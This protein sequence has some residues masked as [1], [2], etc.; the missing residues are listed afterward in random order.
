MVRAQLV[1]P[2]VRGRGGPWLRSS[3][4]RTACLLEAVE[5]PGDDGAADGR[6]HGGEV[7]V[8]ADGLGQLDLAV[9]EVV[10]FGAVLVVFLEPVLPT[11]G[12]RP[13]TAGPWPRSPSSDDRR[14]APRGCGGC[15]TP[16]SAPHAPRRS[17]RRPGQRR[18]R[19]PGGGTGRGGPAGGRRWWAPGAGTPTPTP[20]CGHPGRP[21][22]CGRPT[23]RAAGP[24]RHPCVPRRHATRPAR[25]RARGHST[26]DIDGRGDIEAGM[27]RP[28]HRRRP[29]GTHVRIVPRGGD[30]TRGPNRPSAQENSGER[31][32]AS[33]IESSLGQEGSSMVVT[34]RRRRVSS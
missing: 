15:H 7:P 24:T 16:R 26:R 21:R 28:R 3:P 19:G 29:L 14:P 33:S 18:S 12:R 31:C 11:P 27:D 8:P 17:P 13:S 5:L 32:T 9:R 4:S 25:P 34:A 10:G 20:P 23:P 6:E 1:R 2:A 22:A 30:T